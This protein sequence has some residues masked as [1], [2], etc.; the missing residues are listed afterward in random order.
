MPEGFQD[1]AGRTFRNVDL[2]NDQ[3]KERLAGRRLLGFQLG[4]SVPP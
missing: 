1:W 3:L 2:S 4:S